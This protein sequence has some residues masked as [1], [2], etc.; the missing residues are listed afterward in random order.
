[1]P[2]ATPV[3]QTSG[4]WTPT[5][6]SGASL[7]LIFDNNR[8]VSTGSTVQAQANILYPTTVNTNSAMISGFPV[9]TTGG[10]SVVIPMDTNGSIDIYGGLSGTTLNIFNATTGLA[11]TNAQL[12]GL[13]IL[14]NSGYIP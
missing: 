2:I 13:K 4:G 6:A 5:D 11:V 12:S 1:M 3:I 14:I 9:G 10:T 8:Y 7:T